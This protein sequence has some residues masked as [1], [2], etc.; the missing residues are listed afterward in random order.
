VAH[1]REN[2][3]L[4]QVSALIKR[5]TRRFAKRQLTWFRA[6][7]ELQWVAYPENSATIL[8]TATSFFR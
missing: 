1:L 7:P 2:L 3:E 8:E 4:E 5:N 6:E